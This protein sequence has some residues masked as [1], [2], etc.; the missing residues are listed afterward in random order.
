MDWLNWS[1]P[2]IS[3]Y[4]SWY[5]ILPSILAYI[6]LPFITF[7][8]FCKYSRG[9][10]KWYQGIL[11]IALSIG[12]H[13]I[14]LWFQIPGSL[15]L[16]AE[17]LLLAGSGVI[18]LKRKWTECLMVS[19]L[20]IS[21]LNVCN[22]LMGWLSH[23][24]LFP[25]VFEHENLII[26]SDAVRELCR[27]VFV[28]CLFTI[29]LSRFGPSLM[30][31]NRQTLFQLTIPVFFISLVERII[32]ETFYGDV[33][34]VDYYTHEVFPVVAVDHIE[35]LF[36]Q[37]FACICLVM[38]LFA[39][40]KIIKILHAEQKAQLLE[41][42]AA[43]QEIYIQEAMMR[44]KQTRSFR[45]DIKN[46]LTVLAELLKTDQKDKAC[47]Y[48]SNLE[49]V[50]VGL[51]YPVNTGNIAVDALLGSKLS[52][53]EQKKIRI[54]CE[55]TIPG[56]NDMKDMDWC[57]ILSNALDNAMKA[58]EDVSE[59]ER[60]IHIKSRKKGNFYLLVIENSCDKAIKKVPKDGTGL[61][62]I[63][64]VME[65]HNGTMENTILNGSYK[66]K[67]LF[68]SLQH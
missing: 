21:L 66:V 62:N 10:F 9:S 24:L 4:L 54:C 36:L 20:I 33:I 27:I 52:I 23:R 60:Y 67:L 58:C 41:R 7:L 8:Y 35:L 26:P 2:D 39:Y 45:H 34:E 43:E 29:I 15:C 38:M 5:I 30:E 28:L 65:Q 32:Q 50:S 47:E 37:I 11:Y 44:Y 63:R 6:I 61:C 31:T 57:I 55:L 46:H 13:G 1:I 40:E 51:S 48:L 3:Y 56:D 64:T 22:G 16:T 42:Q 59:E 18:V 68:G 17:I 49:Q 19:V 14:K 25:I 53:A 12:L